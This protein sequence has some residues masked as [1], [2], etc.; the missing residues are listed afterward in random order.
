L[1]PKKNGEIYNKTDAHVLVAI[2]N[3]L[4]LAVQNALRFEEISQFNIKLE[5]RI[6]E[7]TRELRS[8]NARLRKLD[9]TK[10]DFISMASHQ[11]RTPLTSVKGYVSMVLDG[12]AG[13]VSE[14][15]RKLLMQAFISS[16][17]MVG[18]ISD[19]LNV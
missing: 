11:L 4:V 17:R 1:G 12:D 2:A 3:A 19:L 15:Q 13:Q 9:H 14:S 8:A 18:L 6:D 5:E 16:Q 7:R 10:D